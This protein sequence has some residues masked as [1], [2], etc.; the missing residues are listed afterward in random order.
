MGTIADF[1]A[2]LTGGGARPNQFRVRLVF[3]AD[4]TNGLQAADKAQ[5]L[6]KAASLPPSVIENIELFYRGRQVGI[7]GEPSFEPWNVTIYNDT[8]FDIRDAFERWMHLI[9]KYNAT[10]GK[11]NPIDYQVDMEVDQLGRCD[12]VLKTYKFIDVY[13]TRVGEIELAFDSKELET[14]QVTLQ[15]NYFE[16]SN[17]I[18]Q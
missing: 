5:F 12:E 7:A 15:Y 9:A 3:P 1:K 14:F 2:K 13:P 17:V 10:C 11:T 4:I 18:T 6:C 16:P 8:D